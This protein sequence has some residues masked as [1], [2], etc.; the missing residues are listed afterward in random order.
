MVLRSIFS[1]ESVF[2]KKWG[3]WQNLINKFK[4]LKIHLYGWKI[5]GACYEV[6]SKQIFIFGNLKN[7]FWQILKWTKF[8]DLFWKY[9][10]YIYI[11]I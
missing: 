1:V 11:Y 4:N 2:E 6:P 5:G 7:L 8:L 3:V 9:F 10:F